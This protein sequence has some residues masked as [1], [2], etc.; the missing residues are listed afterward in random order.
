LAGL[1]KGAV[2]SGEELIDNAARKAELLQRFPE[3][4]GGEMEGTG[5]SAASFYERRPWILIKAICDW[6]DG[7]KNSYHQPLAAAAA[8][9]LV[10]HVLSDP[11][12]LD[13]E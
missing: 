9:S 5:L 7:V 2:L 1:H 11:D 3:A 4:I 6:A 13:S 12:A 10:H 8:A